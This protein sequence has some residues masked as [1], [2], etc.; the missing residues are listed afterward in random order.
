MQCLKRVGDNGVALLINML[1]AL[2]T[3]KVGQNA[4][5]LRTRFLRDFTRKRDP[6]YAY[7]PNGVAKQVH[8]DRLL[9]STF[10]TGTQGIIDLQSDSRVRT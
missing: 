4:Y 1:E 8:I 5:Q 6:N 3:T 2:S 9:P 7:C 10:S